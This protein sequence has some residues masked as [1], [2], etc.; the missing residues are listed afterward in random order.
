MPNTPKKNTH[1]YLLRMYEDSLIKRQLGKQ[2]KDAYCAQGF[3]A[4]KIAMVLNIPVNQLKLYEKGEID[5][6]LSHLIRLAKLLA[7]PPIE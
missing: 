3:S 6:T 5:F 2:I 1:S 7:R 4:E